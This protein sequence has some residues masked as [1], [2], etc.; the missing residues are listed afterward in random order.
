MSHSGEFPSTVHWR[1]YRTESLTHT[2]RTIEYNWEQKNP[3]NIKW[4]AFYNDCK[5]EVLPGA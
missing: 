2:E 5:Q 3:V 1:S 4:A